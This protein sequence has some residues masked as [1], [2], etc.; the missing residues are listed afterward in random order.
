MQYYQNTIM[1]KKILCFVTLISTFLTIKGYN[2]IPNDLSSWCKQTPYSEQCEYYLNQNKNT[3]PIKQ[4]QDFLTMMIQSAMQNT[5]QAHQ[6]AYSLSTNGDGDDIEKAVWK[7][8]LDMYELAIDHL[9]QTITKTNNNKCTKHDSQTWLSSSLTLHQACLNGFYDLNLT[10]KFTSTL[11]HNFNISSL[12]SNALAINND[13]VSPGDNT[14]TPV[15]TATRD[16]FPTWV[17]PRDRKLLQ[18]GP[19]RGDLVVA[20]DGTGDFSTIGQAISAASSRSKG[21]RFVIYIKAGIYKENIEIGLKNIMLSGDGMGKTI[22]TGS[23][24]VGGGATTFRSA[25]VAAVG[26]GFMAQGI[27]FRNTAGPSNHQAVAFRSNSDLSVFYKCGFEGY[28]D[29]LYVFTNRQFY[30]E[31]NIYGT[32]DFI[33]G[34]AAAVLQNCNIL[35]RNPPAG[36]NTLTAQGRTDPN[37]NTGIVIHNCRVS[38]AESQNGAKTYLGRPWQQYSRTVYMKTYLDSI[39]NPR[40]WLEWSGNFA[41]STLY[42]AEYANTGPGS[43]TAGRVNWPGYHVIGAAEAGKFTVGSFIAGGSWLPATSVPFVSGL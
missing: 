2:T 43:S 24:S 32:V 36:T 41:L 11:S 4:K 39:V 21:G 12:I 13:R 28:Q 14:A 16:G 34:N 35:A 15:A 31:C 26:S 23:K 25:T 7:D 5:L 18:A 17:S 6:N 8:C 33:F 10:N 3:F 38:A 9:N 20:Q 27:T 30:R 29:T 22:I 1:L 19:G 40:G 37:Q 42:Y